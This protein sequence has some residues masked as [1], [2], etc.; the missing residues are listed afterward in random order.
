MTCVHTRT[1]GSRK[2]LISGWVPTFHPVEFPIHIKGP[3]RIAIRISLCLIG[4]SM[5]LLSK[6]FSMSGDDV[7]Q[8]QLGHNVF[9]FLTQWPHKLPGSAIGNNYGALFGFISTGL[10]RLLMTHY[11][12]ERVRPAA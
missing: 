12:D 1:K 6:D 10:A 11:A 4:L 5:L 2:G 3:L 9:D 8:M 7:A